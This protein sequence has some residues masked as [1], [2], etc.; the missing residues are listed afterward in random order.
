MPFPRVGG[1]VPVSD[2]ER[3]DE[4]DMTSLDFSLSVARISD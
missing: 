4:L 3:P 2:V 1:I